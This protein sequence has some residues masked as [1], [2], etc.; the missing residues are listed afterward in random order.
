GWREVLKKFKMKIHHLLKTLEKYIVD[1]EGFTPP[2]EDVAHVRR[3]VRTHRARERLCLNVEIE[4]Y[5]LG[6]LNEPANYKAVL[7]DPESNK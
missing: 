5:S 4:V 7:L 3:S 1:P 2:Q 6:D